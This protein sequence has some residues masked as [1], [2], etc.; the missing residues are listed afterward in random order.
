MPTIRSADPR[1]DAWATTALREYY[2]EEAKRLGCSIDDLLTAEA[3]FRAMAVDEPSSATDKLKALG[4]YRAGLMN[5]DQLV[6]IL[7][8]DNA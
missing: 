3:T 5:D 2:A 4:M 1:V 6:G 8:P 7:F